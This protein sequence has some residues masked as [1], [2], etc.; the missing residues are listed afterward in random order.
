MMDEGLARRPARAWL[1][2]GVL[3]CHSACARSPTPDRP[4][5]PV[6]L[7]E[8]AVPLPLECDRHVQ[9]YCV[10]E[11]GDTAP[12]YVARFSLSSSP[13]CWAALQRNFLHRAPQ[14]FAWATV[15][16]AAPSPCPPSSRVYL[17]DQTA[18]VGF[19]S[20]ENRLLVSVTG[21]VPSADNVAAVEDLL[22]AG[23]PVCPW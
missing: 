3:L 2:V 6:R 14:G 4:P 9:S 19:C 12:S 1:V 5:N 16:S 21:F 23:S 7:L 18:T 8:T 17:S 15:D 22:H 13:D 20:S 11:L 10:R